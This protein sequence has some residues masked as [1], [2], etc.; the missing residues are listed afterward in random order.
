MDR[1]GRRVAG[2]GVRQ[3]RHRVALEGAGNRRDD[4]L[5]AAFPLVLT[6]TALGA[7][8]ELEGIEPVLATQLAEALG[9][10]LRRDV[11]LHRRGIGAQPSRRA[12]QQRRHWHAF[13]LSAQ[14]PQRR[15]DAGDG[16]ADV[17][18]R[19]LVLL[20]GGAVEEIVLI[21]ELH[22]ED[23]R[24]DLAVQHG[25]ADVGLVGGELAP[26]GGAGGVRHAHEPHV[27]G[28]E[29][30]D[31]CQPHDIPAYCLMIHLARQSV[32]R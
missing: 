18:A 25:R 31:A 13:G 7:D 32:C 14:V 23:V 8:A 12:A 9:L 19:E 20:L 26:A 6:T 30:F 17:G 27:G 5:R 10:G 11:A 2:V 1:G 16:P 3:Q 28:R 4:R 29:G 22:A 24:R 21:L 15:V